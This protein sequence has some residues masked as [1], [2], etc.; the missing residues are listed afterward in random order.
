MSKI[1]KKSVD[2]FK[3]LCGGVSSY[4]QI[5]DEE[6]QQHIDFIFE[7]MLAEGYSENA[8][9]AFVENCTEVELYEKFGINW[10]LKQ[11]GK[12]K[13][14]FKKGAK[15]AASSVDDVAKSGQ[16]ALP[17]ASSVDDV[18]KSGQKALPPAGQTS[19]STT[20]YRNQGVG[21]VEKVTS[22]TKPSR[23]SKLKSGLKGPAKFGA[24][25]L[26][27][28]GLYMLGRKQGYDSGVADA[29]GNAGADGGGGGGGGGDGGGGGSGSNDSGGSTKGTFPGGQT[30]QQ[31][32]DINRKYRE[33]IAQ[34]KTKEAEA[35]GKEMHAK[36]YNRPAP[37]AAP[38][39]EPNTKDELDTLQRRAMLDT[40]EK[41]PNAERIVQNNPKVRDALKT[42]LRNSSGLT[43]GP[44][45]AKIDKDSV[46]RAIEAEKKR[47]KERAEKAQKQQSESF[48]AYDIVLNYLF[49]M[50][51]VDTIDEANYI[52]LEM[53]S[54]TIQNIIEQY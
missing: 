9:Y 21:R 52:M 25:T 29:G 4:D 50:G 14:L 40:V 51:H 36:L 20:T 35:Y 5:I 24:Y 15:P 3:S 22:S 49:E 38:K 12:L 33:L 32:A 31:G 19:G 26:G 45:G 46:D 39:V 2:D 13:G 28:A 54:Q 53:D 42:E 43:Q 10:G 47:Q 27:G 41:S 44:A 37:E 7:S 17:P 6:T 16:R 8:I 11:V 48:D 23:L 34:G 18:A 30:R 1:T